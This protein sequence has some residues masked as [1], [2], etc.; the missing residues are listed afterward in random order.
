MSRIL[1]SGLVLFEN[2]NYIVVN[3]PPLISS[4]EDRNDNVNML[5]LA[6]SYHQDVQL[7]HRLD[8]ETSGALVIAKNPEAYRHMS[9][10]FENRQVNK[11]YHALVSGLYSY[12]DKTIDQPIYKLSNGTVRVDRRGKDSVT[13]LNTLKA[14]KL[15]TLLGCQPVTG[16][17]HQIRVHLAYE[18]SPIVNDPT[19][20]GG[21]VY[22]SEVKRKYNLKKGTEEQPLIKRLALH[23]QSI[24]FKSLN[25]EQIEVKAPYP[26]DF[27]VLIKQLEKNC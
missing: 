8:K 17:M 22:L 12:K 16:R 10:Q 26:K 21:T 24:S 11:K 27:A 6:R 15:H 23:S 14:F 7:C 25:N 13:I 2:D 9:M 18:G 3:K 4:L 19:Y 5:G 20:G 1:F